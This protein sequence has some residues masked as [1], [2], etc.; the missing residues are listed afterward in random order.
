MPKRDIYFG[1]LHGGDTLETK[2]CRWRH[3]NLLYRGGRLLNDSRYYFRLRTSDSLTGA[4]AREVHGIETVELAI[5]TNGSVRSLI[6][7]PNTS[8]P[9]R[10]GLRVQNS[11]PPGMSNE[12]FCN[13]VESPVRWA[14]RWAHYYKTC[15]LQLGFSTSTNEKTR[16]LLTW[17]MTSRF[18]QAVKCSHSHVG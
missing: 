17:K 6:C 16:T 8:A 1:F 11:S 7:D 9:S 12:T 3:L 18:R 10:W 2:S 4:R 15:L 5:I 14:R 13:T